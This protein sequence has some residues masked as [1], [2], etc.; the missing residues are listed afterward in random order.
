MKVAIIGGGIVGLAVAYRLTARYPN[1][2]VFVLE[3]EVTPGRHQSGHNSG[4]LHCGLYYRPGSLKARLAVTGI[5]KMVAFC[6]AHSIPFNL[7]GKIV[8]ATDENEVQ[9]LRGLHERGMANGL[10][11]VKLL[12]REEIPEYEPFAAGIEALH[13]PQ[14]GIVDY[15]AVTAAMAACITAEGAEVICGA[16][17]TALHR[18]TH[19]RVG[20]TLGEYEADFVINCAGLHSDR[21]ARIA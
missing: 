9:R 2:H 14:E 3:K 16:K 20:T 1:A 12:K 18:T 11:G 15:G 8:V 7:C 6:E 19:W 5:Q 4:V 13:V 21:V 17:V 10:R